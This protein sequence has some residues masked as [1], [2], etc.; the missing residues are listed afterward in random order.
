ML[1]HVASR[2]KTKR[3]DARPAK[4]SLKE[5]DFLGDDWAED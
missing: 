1:R 4:A 2:W 5:S 3:V